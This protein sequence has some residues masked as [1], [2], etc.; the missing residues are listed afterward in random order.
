MEEKLALK[1]MQSTD[2]YII[3][4]GGQKF[5]VLKIALSIMV[6]I[7]HTKPLPDCFMPLLRIAVPLFFIMSS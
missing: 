4:V 3:I 7:I 5:D 6:V 1:A 2:N